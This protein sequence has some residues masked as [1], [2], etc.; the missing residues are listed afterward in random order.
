[1]KTFLID[2]TI[3]IILNLIIFLGIW[4]GLDY[5]FKTKYFIAIMLV[6]S[7]FSLWVIMYFKYKKF[8]LELETLNPKKDGQ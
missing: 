4:Y 1:M 8:I 5:I 3:V 7:I 2:F 6:L